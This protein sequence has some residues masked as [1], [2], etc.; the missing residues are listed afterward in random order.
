MSD[1]HE[2][3][4]AVAFDGR[5]M[6]GSGNQFGNRMDVRNRVWAIDG[7][8]TLAKSMSVTKA[9][10]DKAREQAQGL[11]PM[12]AIRFYGDERLKTFEDWSLVR[13]DDLVEILTELEEARATLQDYV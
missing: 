11:R 8:S 10:L 6:P 9:M 3:D 4:L 7:K 2:E 5:V 1:K 13:Q 12:I